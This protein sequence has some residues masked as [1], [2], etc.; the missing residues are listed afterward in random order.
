MIDLDARRAEANAVPKSFTLGGQVF[1]L[2]SEL[3]GDVLAPFLSDDLGLVDLIGEAM[4]GND[5]AGVSDMLFDALAKRPTLPAGLL[6][7]AKTAFETLIGVDRFPAFMAAR[8]SVPDY[9][10]LVRGLLAEYGL[11][12][13]DFFGSGSSSG[14]EETNSKQTSPGTTTDPTATSAESGDVPPAPAELVTPAIPD[15]LASAG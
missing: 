9:V 12:L 6:A 5:Q 15:S 13:G 14:N 1:D 8:P 4:S 3:P 2:P 7:A 10:F 11:S